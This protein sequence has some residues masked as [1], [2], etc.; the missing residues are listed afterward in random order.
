MARKPKP[1]KST[2]RGGAVKLAEGPLDSAT[3]SEMS[4]AQMSK[5]IDI[6]Q[7]RRKSYH[8]KLLSEK[9]KY[10]NKAKIL[11]GDKQKYDKKISEQLEKSQEQKI[12]EAKINNENAKISLQVA[13][14]SFK[15]FI[16]AIG[17][18]FVQLWKMIADIG[19]GT[20]KFAERINAFT[21]TVVTTCDKISQFFRDLFNSIMKVVNSKPVAFFLIILLMLF[22][23]FLIMCFILFLLWLIWPDAVAK[24]WNE[25]FGGGQNGE[26]EKADEDCA[27]VTEI[28][29]SNFGKISQFGTKI[30][31]L[32]GNVYDSINVA[33]IGSYRPDFPSIPRT[34]E[35]NLLNPFRSLQGAINNVKF[36]AMNS[37]IIKGFQNVV[38]VIKP[39]VSMKTPRENIENGRSNNVIMIDAELI[40]NDAILNEKDIILSKTAMN[41]AKPEDVKW[42]MNENDFKNKDYNKIPNYLRK[43]KDENDVSIDDKKTI[44]I[45]WVKNNNSY[46]LSCSDAYFE[47]NV[48]EKANILVD[49]NDRTCTFNIES[50]AISYENP[51]K[52]YKFTNDL[53]SFI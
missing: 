37:D 14:I 47:N 6:M 48:D 5:H 32:L 52:R 16:Q 2:K 51:K 25:I 11:K 30:N 8:D 1:T 41:I 36:K 21:N 44:I 29:I 27:N 28:N 40:N 46:E 49:N 22:A 13:Y 24:K 53:S 23:L 26:E 17:R 50:T 35:F 15:N 45:P 4:N 10:E 43:M 3:H 33:N 12:N 9:E 19:K 38:S 34:S 7:N 42:Q 39:P 20:H 18:A 31:E